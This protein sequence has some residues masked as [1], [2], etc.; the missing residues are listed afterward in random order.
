MDC[1]TCA[2]HSVP[3]LV[4]SANWK[5][6]V[7]TSTAGVI[8]W[9]MV[10]ATS[11]L[12]MPPTTMPLTPPLG[13]CSAVT[14]P[15]FTALTISSGRVARA[16]PF[17]EPPKQLGIVDGI[18]KRAEVVGSHARL[19]LRRHLIGDARK[20]RNNR[21]CSK[22]NGTSG[23]CN[24]TSSGQRIACHWGSPRRILERSQSVVVTRGN[25][26]TRA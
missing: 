13:F 19:V 9:L 22:E 3:A 25:G 20:L 11:F 23:W 6:A 10:R 21:S 14:R 16:K 5:G 7:A 2:T 12:T 4:E 1:N 18:E 26:F 15:I 24:K 17:A 8:C